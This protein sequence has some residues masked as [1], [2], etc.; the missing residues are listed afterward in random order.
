MLWS[1]DQR[2]MCTNDYFFFYPALQGGIRLLRGRAHVHVHMHKRQCHNAI[3]RNHPVCASILI[4]NTTFCRSL[5]KKNWKIKNAR[6]ML[7]TSVSKSLWFLQSPYNSVV[8]P[9]VTPVCRWVG[10]ITP[11]YY[12]FHRDSLPAPPW[13]HINAVARGSCLVNPPL[14]QSESV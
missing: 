10:T 5:R 2:L 7:M 6:N 11:S 14:R 1:G 3:F 4:L 8:L 9:N 13:K 12:Q